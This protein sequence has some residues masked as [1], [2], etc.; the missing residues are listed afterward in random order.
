[1]TLVIM[2]AAVV[3]TAIK[4]VVVSFII[5]VSAASITRT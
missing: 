2:L 3:T 1:M 4:S 5:F